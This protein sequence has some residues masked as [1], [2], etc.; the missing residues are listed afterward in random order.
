MMNSTIQSI[1][2]NDNLEIVLNTS[3]AVAGALANRL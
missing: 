3:L 1:K 2:I